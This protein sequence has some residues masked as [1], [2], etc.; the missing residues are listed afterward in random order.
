MKTLL[1]LFF[2]ICTCLPIWAEE[3]QSG[4]A[5]GLTAKEAFLRL[6]GDELQLIPE[7]TRRDMV[8]CYEAKQK[9]TPLNALRDY[10]ELKELTDNYAAVTVSKVSSVQIAVLPAGKKQIVAVIYTV[11]DGNSP[12]SELRLYDEALRPLPVN[13]YFREPQLEMFM[14]KGKEAQQAQA[15]VPFLLV[16]YKFNLSG[17]TPA[18]EATLNIKG[19]MNVEDFDRISPYLTRKTLVY[20]WN[21][22]R[23]SAPSATLTT[24]NTETSNA[25]DLQ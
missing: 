25:T 1:S 2:C 3:T 12:D 17:H 7:S 14:A 23:F 15:L 4:H 19:S 24:Q 9:Y 18:L 8:L 5:A 11:N 6:E 16:S 13:K 10:C 20:D 21:G 22:K